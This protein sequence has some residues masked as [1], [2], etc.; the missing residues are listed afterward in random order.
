[1]MYR[2]KR[3]HFCA[4]LKG[5]AAISALLFAQPVFAQDD[6]TK[7]SGTSSGTDL[8]EKEIREIVVTG[9]LIRGIAPAG[10]NVIGVSQDD[11][12]STGVTTVAQLLQTIPQLGQFNTLQ[13]PAGAF[14]NV[15]T[16][17]PNL[18][19]LPGF[20]TAGSSPTLVLVD[21]HRIVGMGIQSTSPD[22]D[23]LPPGIIDHVEIVPDGGSAIYG[24]DAVAGVI[25][26]ITRKSFDG[27]QVDSHY[28]F[29][30]NYHALDA[31]ATAGKDWGTG[32][33]YLSYNYSEHGDI[34]GRDRDYVR[35]YPKTVA[36]VPFPVTSLRCSPGNVQLVPSGTVYALPYSTGTAAA[37]TA[38]QCDES[39]GA[40]IY[41]REHRH[42]V[43]AGLTQNLND[44]IRVDLRAFYS[45]RKVAAS[46]GPIYDSQY[47]GPAFFGLTPS[48][49]MA[50][51]RVN[52]A[53]PF[54]IHQVSYSYGDNDVQQQRLS[55]SAWGVTP[56]ITA[57]L[58][59]GWQLRALGSYG[60]S[61]TENH[62]GQYNSTAV[63]LAIRAGLLNPYDINSSTPLGLQALTDYESFGLTR[64]ELLNTRLILD[65]SLFELPAGA[66]KL[67]G[68]LEY[69]REGLRSQKGAI[70]PGTENTGY[71]GLFFGGN[72]IVAPYGN[73]PIVSLSRNTKS[74]FGEIVVPIFGGDNS[75]PGLRQL[76]VSAS[77][78]YDK[79]SDFGDTFNP[80]FGITYRPVQWVKVR[81]AWGK[82]FVAPSLADDARVDVT[83][84]NQVTGLSFLLPPANLVASGQYPAPGNSNVAVVLGSAP[85]IKP[86]KATTWSLGADI[87]PPFVPGL[88]LSVTYWNIKFKDLITI[89]S[90]T[91][92]VDFWTN[93]GSVIITNPT[94]AQINSYLAQSTSIVGSGCSTAGT[95]AT[96]CYAI[97]DARKR[98]FA[99]VQLDGLDFAVRYTVPTGF[100]S[101]DFM[102]SANYELNRKQ[103]PI[104]GAAFSDLLSANNSRFKS[105]TMLGTTVGGLRAQVTWNHSGGY[106]LNPA[107]G[108]DGVQT[109]V[110][111]FDVFNLFFKYDVSGSGM[112][113]DLSFTLNVDN[114]FD[115]APPV[116][117]QQSITASQDGYING[118]TIGRFFQFGVSKKF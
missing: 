110:K 60:E 95:G 78:R 105:S 39:D 8:S 17:R 86:E 100:G 114:V 50:A 63:P 56:T 65:G 71:S 96:G 20:Q 15:T 12:K 29:A 111:S 38:N 42:S 24:S 34:Y 47:I 41:P 92:Q 80:K 23:V 84:Y 45:E 102:G 22:P 76:T 1:M 54:E 117:L 14:N 7:E 13:Q 88:N 87:E 62:V 112:F 83:S 36:G 99:N 116:F 58:G 113:K 75:M 5:G 43:F 109:K 25:N 81:A 104:A 94:Q 49:F 9:T 46:L 61:T 37:N 2:E 91:N 18:R 89:P 79:Y 64:Q 68:G 30:D 57:E 16:N 33:L 103:Q 70:V 97:L 31:S 27:L 48:P 35:M 98:N 69:S 85:G 3:A 106:G 55:L 107:V 44:S 28:G 118:N 40:P 90:F 108:V 77:G 51:H 52:P 72:A 6:T 26:F 74:A 115:K 67:A 53:N 59:K 101:I 4:V 21:G 10:T 66:V 11:V 19:N 82:S 93:F 32:S 73:I